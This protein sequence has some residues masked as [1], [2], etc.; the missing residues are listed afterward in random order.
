MEPI[1]IYVNEG[2]TNKLCGSE[3]YLTKIIAEAHLN[4]KITQRRKTESYF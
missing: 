3:K 2:A 1:Y 4:D